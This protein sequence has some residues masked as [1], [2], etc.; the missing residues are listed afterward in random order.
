MNVFVGWWALPLAVTIAAFGWAILFDIHK[1]RPYY[2][3]EIGISAAL[4]I[5]AAA[6]SALAWLTYAAVA[7]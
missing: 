5:L 4:Y 6:V 7:H 3:I 1:P 2:G